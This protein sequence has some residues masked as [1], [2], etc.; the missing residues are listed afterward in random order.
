MKMKALK[1]IYNNFNEL[2]CKKKAGTSENI[3]KLEKLRE[4][5]SNVLAWKI[6]WTEE[7]GGLQSMVLQ[8]ARYDLATKSPMERKQVSS[9]Q[10]KN[11]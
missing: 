7:P 10:W 3:H 4:S 2:Y 8:R 11:L 5:H 1:I 9:F 6:P